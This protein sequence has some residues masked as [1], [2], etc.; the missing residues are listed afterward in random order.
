MK[1]IMRLKEV[2]PL[3]SRSY[4]DKATG[5]EV[6]IHWVELKLTDGCDTIIGELVVPKTRDDSGASAVRQPEFMP[7]TVYAVDFNIDGACGVTEDGKRW[8]RNR[9]KINKVVSL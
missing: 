7:E 3:L 1:Q 6:S 9:V 5:A 2:S 4:P 8:N